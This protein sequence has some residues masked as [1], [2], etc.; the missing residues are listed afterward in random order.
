MVTSPSAVSV[1]TAQPSKQSLTAVTVTK[2]TPIAYS[3]LIM[4]RRE[5]IYPSKASGFADHLTFVPERWETWTPRPFTYIPF[6]GGPRI[7]IGQQFA[8]TEMAYTVVRILQTYKK[9]ESRNDGFPGLRSDI[10][11]QPEKGEF[12]ISHFAVDLIV[13][14]SCRCIRRFQLKGC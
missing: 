2:D 1:P 11:L 6:N 12:C 14:T 13:L 4:Q 3:T 7:C 10:V 9:V 8:L 5:D